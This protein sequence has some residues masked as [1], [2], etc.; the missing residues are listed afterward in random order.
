MF[1]F[2]MYLSSPFACEMFLW[3]VHSRHS[4]ELPLL[5]I[6]LFHTTEGKEGQEVLTGC[7][8][9]VGFGCRPELLKLALE[10]DAVKLLISLLSSPAAAGPHQNGDSKAA[11]I[12]SVAAAATAAATAAA[13]ELKRGCLLALAALALQGDAAR[14]Q[15]VDGRLVQLV[16]AALSDTDSGGGPAAVLLYSSI[17]CSP[18]NL[19][20]QPWHVQWIFKRMLI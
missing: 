4:F 16:V 3:D 15:M 14:Q 6:G 5:F 20:V 7:G 10:L 19:Y 17:P 11:D 1:L 18:S 12:L 13:V 9:A 2:M 8:C